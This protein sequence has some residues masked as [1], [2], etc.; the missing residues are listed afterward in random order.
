[1]RIDYSNLAQFTRVTAPVATLPQTQVLPALARDDLS[2]LRLARVDLLALQSALSEVAELLGLTRT[3]VGKALE[4][5]SS[6]PLG[7]D[8]TT[9]PTMLESAEEINT[10]PTSFG[11]FGPAWAGSSTALATISGVYDGTSGTGTL[12]FDVRSGGVHGQDRLRIRVQD[13]GG[14]VLQNVFVEANDP[15]DQQYALGNGLSFSLGPGTAVRNDLFTVNVY[16][17]VGSVVETANPFN[18]TRN[19]IPN[20]DPGLAVS[21]GSFLLNGI[22]IDVAADSSVDSILSQIN[23]SAAGVTASFDATRERIVFTQNTLGA[24]PPVVVSGDDS[25][26]IDALKLSGAVAVPGRDRDLDQPLANLAQFQNVQSGTVRINGVDIA[27]DV[28]ADS[29]EEVLDRISQS[30]QDATATYS[31]SPERV[32]LAAVDAGIDLSVDDGG[33]GLFA[34]LGIATGDFRASPKGDRRRAGA[35]TAAVQNVSKTLNDFLA[36][37]RSNGLV[38]TFAAQLDAVLSASL[39]SDFSSGLRLG[40]AGASRLDIDAR[41]MSR[42]LQFDE[43]AARGFLVGEGQGAA[44]GLIGS[45]LDTVDRAIGS[46]DGVIGGRSAVVD[47]FA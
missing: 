28:Q 33:T 2:P 37:D 1:M 20:F 5:M 4:L 26:L 25:G 40:R 22:Q 7:L 34:A 32:V 12:T 23:L 39:T 17:A 19:T 8:N 47:L 9:T 38:K 21:A 16:D 42:A 30:Q 27:I 31:S 13:T 6:S 46:L 10:V 36:R 11:P 44:A 14:S 15:I 43:R 29:L 3:S 18:G 35:I 41:A 45:L 24:A